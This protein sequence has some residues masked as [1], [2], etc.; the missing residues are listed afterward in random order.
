MDEIV[1]TKNFYKYTLTLTRNN[2]DLCD[3][4]TMDSEWWKGWRQKEYQLPLYNLFLV[5][6]YVVFF[7][8]H[9]WIMN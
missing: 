7:S 8:I 4:H 2:I 6:I 3:A 5:R 9:Q 1:H